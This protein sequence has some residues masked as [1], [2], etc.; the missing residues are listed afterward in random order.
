MQTFLYVKFRFW[1]NNHNKKRKV[2]VRA[3]SD[4]ETWSKLKLMSWLVGWLAKKE[5]KGE[6]V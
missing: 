2:K 3:A 4:V 1:Q 6:R 5:I